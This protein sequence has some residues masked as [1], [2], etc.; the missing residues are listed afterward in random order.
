MSD[1][2]MPVSS[3]HNVQVNKRTQGIAND[4]TAPAGAASGTVVIRH[5]NTGGITTVPRSAYEGSYRYNG[6]TEVD[7]EGE[8]DSLY[9]EAIDMGV[10]VPETATGRT[11]VESMR[12]YRRNTREG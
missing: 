6:W 7:V 1:Q 4:P 2:P 8:R 11:I 3:P 9:Q 12:A 5:E 10:N